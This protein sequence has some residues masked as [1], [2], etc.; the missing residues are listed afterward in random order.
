[1]LTEA[2]AWTSNQTIGKSAI[3]QNNRLLSIGT[4]T[5]AKKKTITITI[6]IIIL[7]QS[8]W[9]EIRPLGGKRMC[10]KAE[11]Q[12]FGSLQT[13]TNRLNPRNNHS[14]FKYLQSTGRFNWF[15]PHIFLK[16]PFSVQPNAVKEHNIDRYFVIVLYQKV[17]AV[18]FV[19][20]QTLQS[21]AP[22]PCDAMLAIGSLGRGVNV[23]AIVSTWCAPVRCCV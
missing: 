4:R 20:H 16:K 21:H 23:S 17:I 12:A 2:L 1:M 6:F 5:R 19:Q 7:R 15:F 13:G 11:N 8:L 22:K 9:L 10:W 14:Y 18:T 3:A